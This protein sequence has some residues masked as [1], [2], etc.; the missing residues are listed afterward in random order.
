MRAVL[1]TNVLVSGIFWAGTP[2]QIL[3]LWI[4][5]RFELIL[6]EEIFFE[7]SK[8]LLRISKG[9]RDDLVNRWLLLIAENAH[10][11]KIK[12]HFKLSVDADDDK[13]IDCALSGNAKYIVSG[14]SHLL[15][16]KSILNVQCIS[17]SEFFKKV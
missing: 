13:F 4:S 7:Y 16:L 1:D 9:K 10:F 14:D 8:V 15:D 11:V 2:S 17:P 12:K 6:S 5:D 3:E